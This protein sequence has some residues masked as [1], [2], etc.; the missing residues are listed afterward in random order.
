MR[1]GPGRHQRWHHRHHGHWD[2]RPM[3]LLGWLFRA[4]LQRRL[5]MW[6]G[7]SIFVTGA[8]VAAVVHLTGP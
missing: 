7:F 6:F 8:A 2:G 1:G 3:T 4:R 5:F